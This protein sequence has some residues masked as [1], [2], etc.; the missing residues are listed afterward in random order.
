MAGLGDMFGASLDTVNGGK[1]RNSDRP[2][3]VER[4]N[5]NLIGLASAFADFVPVVGGLKGAYEGA[6]D[7]DVLS[8]LLNAAS[9]PLD[10]ASFGT[11]GTALKGAG[12]IAAGTLARKGSKISDALVP[13]QTIVKSFPSGLSAE[14]RGAPIS[15][16]EPH[17][18]RVTA[19]ISHPNTL[20]TT[21]GYVSDSIA[22]D[23]TRH[24]ASMDEIRKIRSAM[25]QMY[26][27]KRDYLMSREAQNFVNRAP[28]SSI[29]EWAA[30]ITQ[31]QNNNP[32]NLDWWERALDTSSQSVNA[33][34]DG[35]RGTQS[36]FVLPLNTDS[37]RL[38][39]VA[40]HFSQGSKQPIGVEY[41]GDTAR[42][43]SKSGN[44]DIMH[45]ESESPVIRSLNA[46][47]QGKKSGMGKEFYQAAYNWAENNGKV[48]APDSGITE[49][50]DLRKTGN[51]LSAQVRNGGRPVVE[52]NTSQLDGIQD[53][54][55]LWK[56]E[57]SIANSRLPE[58]KG[59]KF[60]GKSFN[61]TDS[62][63]EKLIKSKNANFSKG[64][65]T[66]TAKRAALYDWLK[67]ASPEDAKK[68]ASQWG[69]GSVFPAG[70]LMMRDD[71]TTD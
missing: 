24:G 64:V 65:G 4:S 32:A 37:K 61:K 5:D 33:F 34:A 21:T 43:K 55:A 14:I 8:G 28:E 69:G 11:A 13:P 49:I 46:G 1:P 3:N 15:T 54:P 27:S 40:A 19:S 16:M 39:D 2:M 44:L 45:Y 12:L 18:P 70:L 66:L 17:L 6:R 25:G 42:L 29:P 9:V 10:L 68:A 26:D 48:I 51:A 30:S 63:I 62:E 57:A 7:G 23:Y 38:E 56:S 35:I 20:T 67:T 47:S 31:Q 53:V 41:F 58:I 36:A 22:G 50:N 60:D 71:E 59:V 52:M